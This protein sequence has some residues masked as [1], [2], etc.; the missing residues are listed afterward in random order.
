MSFL[1]AA[2][3]GSAYWYLTLQLGGTQDV[4][5]VTVRDSNA[6]GGQEIIAER[7]GETLSTDL[8]HNVHWQFPLPRG[9]LFLLR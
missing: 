9:T 2:S 8:G 5:A 3:G 1:L 4:R 7:L 6:L